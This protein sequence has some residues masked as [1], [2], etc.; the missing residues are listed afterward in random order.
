MMNKWIPKILAGIV[1]IPILIIGIIG[2]LIWNSI[3]LI[4]YVVSK[5]R[6]KRNKLNKIIYKD[7]HK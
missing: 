3:L 5:S 7:I 1:M 2:G 4:D 6:R